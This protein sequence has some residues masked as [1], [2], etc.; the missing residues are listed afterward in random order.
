MYARIRSKHLQPLI[1]VQQRSRKQEIQK[2][3][4]LNKC[5]FKLDPRAF[6]REKNK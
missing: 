6:K 4:Y 2:L 3:V 5:L 1:V